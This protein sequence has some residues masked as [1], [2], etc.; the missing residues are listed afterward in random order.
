[1]KGL[2]K[3]GVLYLKGFALRIHPI[4]EVLVIGVQG[5]NLANRLP[6]GLLTLDPE[7]GIKLPV[8]SGDPQVEKAV[9]TKIL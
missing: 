2:K 5:Y 3:I 9:G 8:L 7:N 4:S 1:L 6:L